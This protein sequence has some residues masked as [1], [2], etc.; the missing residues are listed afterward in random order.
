MG[1]SAPVRAIF[2][3]DQ[4]GDLLLKSGHETGRFHHSSFVAGAAVAAAG[5]MTVHHGRIL[6][7]SNS[8]GHYAPQRSS[9]GPVL[10]HLSRMGVADLGAIEIDLVDP[11]PAT[12]AEDPLAE[13]D[14]G[15]SCEGV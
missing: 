8:S 9:L 15:L 13:E 4:A 7:L 2:V 6:A 12:V 3:I 14:D 11:P 10:Q 1:D 5:E